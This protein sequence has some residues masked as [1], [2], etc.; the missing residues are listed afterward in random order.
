MHGVEWEAVLPE[1]KDIKPN[2]NAHPEDWVDIQPGIGQESNVLGSYR[3]SPPYDE[4]Q[5]TDEIK[6]AIKPPERPK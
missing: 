4:V 1:N 3:W 2:K 6:V 5:R